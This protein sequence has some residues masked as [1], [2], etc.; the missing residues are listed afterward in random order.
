LDGGD[1]GDGAE[2]VGEGFGGAFEVGEDLGEPVGF[3]VFA[4][5]GLEGL[6]EAAGHDEHGETAG[7]DEGD[8]DGLALHAGQVAEQLA[9]EVG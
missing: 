4:P 3:V 7:H 6:D 8:G 2:A 9:V 1:A 5:G